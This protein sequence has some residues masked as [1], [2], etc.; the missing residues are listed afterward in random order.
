MASTQAVSCSPYPGL[1]YFAAFAELLDMERAKNALLC[2]Q[3]MEE[4]NK[5]VTL[6][7]QMTLKQREMRHIGSEGPASSHQVGTYSQAVRQLKIARYKAK[8]KGRIL[9]ARETRGSKGR[10]IVAQTKPRVKGRFVKAQSEKEA[11]NT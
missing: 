6:M 1:A 7:A 10:S 11:V 4:R 9:R 8:L 2:M 5:T 3:L